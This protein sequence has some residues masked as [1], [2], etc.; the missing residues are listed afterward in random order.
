MTFEL[1]VIKIQIETRSLPTTAT[2]FLGF[3]AIKQGKVQD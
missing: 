2:F 1:G 3:R